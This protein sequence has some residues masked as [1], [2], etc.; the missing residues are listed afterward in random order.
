M[1]FAYPEYLLLLPV[2]FIIWLWARRPR[3]YLLIPSGGQGKRSNLLS[4]LVLSLPLICW[5][6]ISSIFIFALAN[7]KKEFNTTNVVVEKKIFMV[8]IDVSTSMG[9]GPGSTMEKIKVMAA[10]FV[11][12]RAGDVIGISAYS[13]SFDPSRVR[14]A[15]YARIIMYPTEDIAQVE[16]AISS[17][18][19]TMFGAYTAIGDGIFVS[20]IA[21]IEQEAKEKMGS[22]YDRW[23]LDASV[24]SLGEKNEDLSYA[25]E[26]ANSIGPQTGKFIL[27]FTDGKYN[28]GMNPIK[29]IWFA[30]RLGIKVHFI[31][32][33]SSAAT[34]LSQEEQ[35]KHKQDT[36]V[37][38]LS[39][40]GVYKE[41]YDI[42]GVA[43]LF[44]EINRI[45]KSRFIVEGE[46]REENQRQNFFLL[47]AFIFLVWVI[48]ENL[49]IK[50]P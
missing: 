5:L 27:L 23:L 49:W 34:G 33:D 12:K 36:I 46:V 22:R 25:Q 39:S 30:R 48:I 17:T 28:T 35:I 19:A 44:D 38:V 31:A 21:L 11:R 4:R 15:G 43:K 32:F 41:S 6:A 42:S 37:A 7:P 13:G 9:R 3:Q 2:F 18:E 10:D 8:S 20:I 47:S 40:G 26:I 45:E 29:A 50:I 24:D 1:A 14:G 16:E